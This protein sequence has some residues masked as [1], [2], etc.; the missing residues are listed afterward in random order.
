VVL[1]SALLAQSPIDKPARVKVE[2]VDLA[3]GSVIS[4]DHLQ[5]VTQ[6]VE[7]RSYLANQLQEIVER[8]RYRL[9]REG[10]FKAEISV[11]ESR[12]ISAI[13][14]TIAVTLTVIEGQ[15]FRLK[16]LTF[17]GSKAFPESQL[18]EQFVIADGDVFD[19]E[20][21]RKG[22]DQLRVLYGSQGYINF[23]PVPNTDADDEARAIML[24]IDCDEGKQYH[25]GK[26]RV[27]GPELHP[28]DREKMLAAWEPN[29]GKPYIG[30]K[31]GRF[32]VDMA[33]YFPGEWKKDQQHSELSFDSATATASLRMVLPGEK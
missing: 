16:R 9:Q 14:G 19:V 17:S 31:V 28:G 30:W 33:P 29:V 8:S 11:A 2:A 1:S 23:T 3:S 12:Q 18:R 32:L 13:N 22:L 6:E 15:Q 5:M 10:Y 21:I 4:S 27:V 26:L 25:F 20:R 24:H 7:S